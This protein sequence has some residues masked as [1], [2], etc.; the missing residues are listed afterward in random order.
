[1]LR[2]GQDTKM[3]T[4]V[5]AHLG[6]QLDCIWNQ[7]KHKPLYTHPCEGFSCKLFESERPIRDV[8]GTFLVAAQ[9]KAHGKQKLLLACLLSPSPASSSTLLL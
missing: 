3:N 4:L 9:I 6:C 2:W 8:G 7:L 5:M 1:M